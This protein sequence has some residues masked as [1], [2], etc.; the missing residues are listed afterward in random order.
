[1][2]TYSLKTELIVKRATAVHGFYGIF[3]S[4]IFN[5]S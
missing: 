1:L 2:T 4:V 5:I 3:I